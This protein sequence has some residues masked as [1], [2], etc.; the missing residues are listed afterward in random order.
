[1]S[2]LRFGRNTQNFESSVQD[3]NVRYLYYSEKTNIARTSRFRVRKNL[4]FIYGFLPKKKEKKNHRMS[5][6]IRILD[7][8]PLAQYIMINDDLFTPF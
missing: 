2:T 7:L 5:Y 8:L 1:M 4:H 6:N 3:I